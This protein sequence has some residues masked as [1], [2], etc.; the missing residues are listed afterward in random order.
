MNLNEKT[1]E[2]LRKLINEETEYRSGPKLIDFFAEFG[3]DEKYGSGFP[4]RWIY[5]DEKLK[6]LNNTSDIDKCIRK[7]FNPINFIEDLS[8]LDDLINDFNKYLSFDGWKVVREKKIITFKKFEEHEWECSIDTKKVNDE[9]QFIELDIKYDLKKLKIES[10]LL[11]VVEERLDEMEKCINNNIPLSAIFLAGSTLEG[12]LLSYA[13]SNIQIYNQA[14]SSPKKDGKVK[15]LYDWTLNDL[16]NVSTEIGFIKEDT[17]KFSTCLRD[18]RNYIHPYQQ[19][20]SCFSPDLNT[21]K[22][23]CQVL[24]LAIVQISQK[25]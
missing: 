4:S 18:F 5:T 25:S 22:I 14:N 23:C 2:K 6:K 21:A 8:K 13:Q 9:R 19:M 15:R 12:I 11:S 3:F 20:Q 24:K 16:I 1:L 17:K 10:N 7:V